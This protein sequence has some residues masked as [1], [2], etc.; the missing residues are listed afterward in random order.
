[1]EGSFTWRC[2]HGRI[3]AYVLMAPPPM[4]QLQALNFS[5]AAP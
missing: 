1:M 5:I 4:P 3:K 2:E